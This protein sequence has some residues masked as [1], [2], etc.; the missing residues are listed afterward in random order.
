MKDVSILGLDL[1]KRVFQLHAAGADGG[2][3]FRKKLS[4]VPVLAFSLSCQG[5]SLRWK[6]VRPRISGVRTRAVRN[7]TLRPNET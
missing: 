6:H 5:V 4:R 7:R 1:A 3:V 2:L